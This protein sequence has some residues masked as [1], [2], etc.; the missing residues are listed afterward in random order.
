MPCSYTDRAQWLDN[1]CLVSVG[2]L[3][4][5]LGNFLHK[6]VLHDFAGRDGDEMPPSGLL[7]AYSRWA[8]ANTEVVNLY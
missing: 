4:V 2:L 5:E 6:Q 8:R 7:F 3:T 1:S